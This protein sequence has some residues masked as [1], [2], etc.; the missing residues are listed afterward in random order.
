MLV[1]LRA[2]RSR[3]ACPLPA[4]WRKKVY[5]YDMLVIAPE[6]TPSS[7]IAAR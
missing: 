6:L 4:A 5:E 1:D 2:L 7:L 3:P